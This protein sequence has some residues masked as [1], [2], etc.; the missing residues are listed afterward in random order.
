MMWIEVPEKKNH[1]SQGFEERKSGKPQMMM[2]VIK[3]M[4][5]T[6]LEELKI[7]IIRGK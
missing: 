1:A 3:D 6:S 2:D 4:T 5:G 7:I